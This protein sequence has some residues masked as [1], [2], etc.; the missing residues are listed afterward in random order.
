MSDKNQEFWKE[1]MGE[2]F[3]VDIPLDDPPSPPEKG[4]PDSPGPAPRP[5]EPAPPAGGFTI[6]YVSLDG[7]AAPSPEGTPKAPDAGEP[8]KT[9][10]MPSGPSSTPQTPS[11]PSGTPQTPSGPS[12]A[13]EGTRPDPG[14]TAAG[15]GGKHA[16]PARGPRPDAGKASGA[17]GSASGGSPRRRQKGRG[18]DF[19]VEFDFDSEYPDVNEKAVRRGRSRRTGCLSGILLFLFVI[20]VSLVLAFVGWEWATD[21]L[22]FDGGDELVEVTLPKSIF[23]TETRTE[24]NDDG[25]E[26]EVTV[27][28]ADM[29]AVAEELYQKGLI[30]YR[31]LFKLFSKFAHGDTKVHAGTYNLNMNYD[32]RALI[33]GMNPRTGK[34]TIVKLTIPE[35]YTISQI[36]SLMEENN[37]CAPE[38]LLDSL[39]NTDFDYDFLDKSTLGDPKRLEGYLFPDTYEFYEND[40]PDSVIKRFLNNFG[41]K[42]TEEFDGK[43]EELGFTAREILTVAS[44]I[45]KEAGADA[46]RATIASVIYNRLKD[47]D[48]RHGTNAYLQIDATIRY[49][50]ADTGEA[51]STE[52]DSPYNTYKYPGLPKGPIANPGLASIKAALDP[53]STKYYYYALGKGGVHRFFET[54]E[55]FSKFVNSDEYGG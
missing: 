35:G 19:E 31:W 14:R 32:Y 44:M 49:A 55:A 25:E 18:D 52:V 16:A 33:N 51:F 8:A 5:A 47:T 39:A 13:P 2:D 36:V 3:K 26:V 34:R 17:A 10:Q 43:A 40:D 12:K 37:V 23:H 30:R 1:L 38:D 4:R 53:A 20:C 15:A 21:V 7:S 54:Y 50:I 42:W 41:R 45:E 27:D 28:A 9:P 29:D 6:E 11:G 46:E 48:G 24:K 22:G